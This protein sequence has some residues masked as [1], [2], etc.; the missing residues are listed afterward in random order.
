MDTRYWGPSGWQ[1]FHLI[2]R[3]PEAEKTLSLLPTILPCKFCR[4]S[5]LD[6]VAELPLSTSPVTGDST[7]RWLYEIHRK[8]NHKL[9]TQCKNDPK[10]INP[11]PDPTFEEVKEKYEAMKPTQVPG[12]D[13]LFAI[14]RNY[15]T[16]NRDIHYNFLNSLRT[17]YPFK[18]L[19]ER[20]EKYFSENP[21]A[22]STKQ[23]YMSWMYNLIA[24]LSNTIKVEMPT[25]RE[26][27]N[28]VGIYVS[29]CS[30]STYRGKTCRGK[31]S[32]KR[33]STLRNT[34]L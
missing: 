21:P 5:T 10:V 28:L 17:T 6:F 18:E 2:A 29:G 31:K 4:A 27:R 7:Q 13:F 19:R 34:L 1:L 30:K 25:K 33:Y 23:G 24:E 9:R 8:V 16:E 26:I 12:R 20:Y 14:A 11:A 22:L 15:T 32:S 3:E